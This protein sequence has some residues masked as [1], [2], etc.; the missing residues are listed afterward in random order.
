MQERC[1]ALCFFGLYN[2]LFSPADFS[3]SIIL[4]LLPNLVLVSDI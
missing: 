2:I 1:I 4:C 3:H